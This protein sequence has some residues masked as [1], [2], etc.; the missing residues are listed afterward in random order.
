MQSQAL[1]PESPVK[2]TPPPKTETR[3]DSNYSLDPTYRMPTPPPKT[4]K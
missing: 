1:P 3:Q 2:P 4:D